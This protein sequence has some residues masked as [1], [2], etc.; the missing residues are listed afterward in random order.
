MINTTQLTTNLKSY[1]NSQLDIVS[2]STP[3]VGFMKPL[4]TRA[5]DKNFNKVTNF[6]ELIANDNGEIDIENILSEMIQNIMSSNP[7]VYKTSFIGDIEIGGGHISFNIPLTD[8]KLILST[9]D[10]EVLKEV[11]ITK[12]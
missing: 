2:K 1:I 12:E 8:K 6:L 9:K 7:F 10:L 11:L 4:I 5:L 3:I